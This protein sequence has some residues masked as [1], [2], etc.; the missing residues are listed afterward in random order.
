VT[1]QTAPGGGIF[2]AGGRSY[3]FDANDVFQFQGVAITQAQFESILAAN[4]TVIAN[5]NPSAA[6]VSTFNVQSVPLAEATSVTTQVRNLDA[7]TVINDVQV[8]YTR[9]AGNPS[10]C[11]VHPAAPCKWWRRRD[12]A[13]VTSATQV[14]GTGTGVFVFTDLNVPNGTYV[15]RVVRHQPGHRCDG[16]DAEHGHG[17]HSGHS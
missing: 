13:T 1:I 14:A 11:D 5:F 17:H 12:F 2:T 16:P 9:P 4:G 8:T 10:W 6:G 15:Y 3:T 7:G